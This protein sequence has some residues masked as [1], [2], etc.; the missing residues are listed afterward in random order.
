MRVL[1]DPQATTYCVRGLNSVQPIAISLI[2]NAQGTQ[3][4]SGSV[5]YRRVGPRLRVLVYT[6]VRI[7]SVLSGFLDSKRLSHLFHT[8][9]AHYTTGSLNDRS[10]DGEEAEKHQYQQLAVAATE[11]LESPHSC[12]AGGEEK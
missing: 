8:F 5:I 3:K 11:G 10:C 12:D 6:E 1:T 4:S 7:S 2:L 9:P